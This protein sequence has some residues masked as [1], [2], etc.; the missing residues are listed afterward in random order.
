MEL[1]ISFIE[2][3]QHLLGEEAAAFFAALTS[4][5]PVKGFRL[6]IAKPQAEAMLAKYGP[7]HEKAPYAP[8][9]YIGEVKGKSLLHQAGYVYSQEPSAMIVAAIADAHPGERVLDLCA[10]PGGKSTQ[11][12]S[13]LQGAGLLVSNEIFPKRA[14]ILAENI[15]RWGFA[16]VVVTNHAPN[17]LSRHFPQ[18]FD[19]IIVDAPCSG[20]GMFRK[21][22]VAVA[23][24][25]SGA[26]EQC[27]NRQ[28]AILIE[29]VKMLKPGGQLIY[30]TCTFAPEE[31]EAI[32]SWLV[33][34]YPFVI[35]PIAMP[36]VA[37]GRPEWGHAADIDKTVRLWPHLNQGEGHFAAKL[38]Y[39]GEAKSIKQKKGKHKEALPKLEQEASKLWET[40]QAT[41]PYLP[42]DEGTLH[43]LGDQLWLVPKTL[44]SLQGL[45]VMRPGLHL[46]TMKKHRI[47]PSYA[48]ALAFL[49]GSQGPTLPIT[50]QQWKQYVA[51][52]T[53]S[54]PGNA[55]WVI[56]QVDEVPV[57]IGK[58]V[59]GIVKNFFP[60]GLRFQAD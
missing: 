52:E 10:A 4:G 1:P 17:E 21:D 18:F 9:A 31:N 46:G 24:W 15:E 58:Q 29:A 41:F 5:Y 44:P 39:Q 54:V 51:G 35:Q 32:I 3:Y 23:E 45:K 49:A 34:N 20:E 59:Q 22:P 55:G 53:I 28:Q 2:K 14:K 40:F 60:K 36:N 42:F 19:K 47:E 50:I 11:L 7:A 26:P 13:Q 6:N 16:N 48:V 12:A 38:H 33:E 37:H 43:M 57:G 27:A 56:L 25:H 30:S 8:N